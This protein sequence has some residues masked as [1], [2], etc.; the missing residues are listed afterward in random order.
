MVIF[1]SKAI[2]KAKKKHTCSVCGGQICNGEFYQQETGKT[3]GKFFCHNLHPACAAAEKSYAMANGYNFTMD[4]VHHSIK[5]E[6]CKACELY[7]AEDQT[8]QKGYSV[9]RCYKIIGKMNP[10][11]KK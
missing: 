9:G 7:S 6:Y 1:L 3:D 5:D 4:Q 8:C 2:Y 11:I 10:T